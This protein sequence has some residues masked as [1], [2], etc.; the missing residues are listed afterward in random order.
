MD[1]SNS[2]LQKLIVQ[3]LTNQGDAHVS[4]TPEMWRDMI[5]AMVKRVEP[6]LQF[7]IKKE[8]SDQIWHLE[9]KK[10]R[11][12]ARLTQNSTVDTDPFDTM[13]NSDMRVAE[14]DL[15]ITTMSAH[16]EQNELYAERIPFDLHRESIMINDKGKLFVLKR[17]FEFGIQK[18]VI[19]ETITEFEFRPLTDDELLAAMKWSDPAGNDIIMSLH[20]LIK[21]HA[22]TMQKRMDKLRVVERNLD[23]ILEHV[24]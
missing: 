23:F 14:L 11:K 20:D 13:A 8:L 6:Y 9:K 5:L 15:Y 17:K 12:G 16:M 22:D 2:E 7:I 3:L 10:L 21:A 18:K 4:L 24:S 1:T 19:V